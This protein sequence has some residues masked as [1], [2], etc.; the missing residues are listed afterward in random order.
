LCPDIVDSTRHLSERGDR[1]WRDL[2]DRFYEILR[3]EIERFKGR[4]IN[5][6]W[7]PNDLATKLNLRRAPPI[8]RVLAT[9]PSVDIV[10]SKEEEVT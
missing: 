8:D 5:A 7:R 3:Q 10:D 4:E 9:V 6:A 1:A 2:L